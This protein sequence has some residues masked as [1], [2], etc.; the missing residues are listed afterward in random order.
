LQTPNNFAE[1]KKGEFQIVEQLLLNS[2]LLGE[3]FVEGGSNP[4][5]KLEYNFNR[6]K[7]KVFVYYQKGVVV[8]FCVILVKI[9]LYN[10]TAYD[11]HIAYFYTNKSYRRKGIG[12]NMLTYVF[13]FLTKTKAGIISLYTNEDNL[14][15]ITLYIKFG[16]KETKYLG[17]YNCYSFCLNDYSNSRQE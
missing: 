6:N 9:N 16:F 17:N 4:I 8:S 3:E 5:P 15:A 2:G 10:N 1:L 12:Y 14:P 11:W 13:N 7:L